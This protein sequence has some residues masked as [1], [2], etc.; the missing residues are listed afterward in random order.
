MINLRFIFSIGS[1]GFFCLR[2]IV[3]KRIKIERYISLDRIKTI[4]ND[5]GYSCY[6]VRVNDINM[7]ENECL[8]VIKNKDNSFHYVVI[9]G[10]VNNKICYYDPLFVN[11]RK[12]RI[13]SFL[14]KWT[15]ICLLYKKIG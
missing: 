11:L 1:C 3:K 2:K 8:S 6:C 15:N 14:K 5:N 13:S 12:V 9:K 10:I 4:L 7:I